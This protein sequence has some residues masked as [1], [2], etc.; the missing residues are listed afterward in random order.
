MPLGV[1]ASYIYNGQHYTQLMPFQGQYYVR[2]TAASVSCDPA[3]VVAGSA[4]TCTAT[5]L[6]TDGVPKTAQPGGVVTFSAQPGGKGTFSSTTCTLF[7]GSCSVTYTPSLTT[8]GSVTITAS[9]QGDPAHA[10]S[11]DSASLV[12]LDP[13]QTTVTG[14]CKGANVPVTTLTTC[15][16]TVVD[17]TGG[18]PTT[19]TGTVTMTDSPSGSGSFGTCTLS[20]VSVGTASCTVSYAPSAGEEGPITITATYNGDSTHSGSSGSTGLT[21]TQIATTTIV[22]CS[23]NPTS[24]NVASTCTATVSDNGGATLR[25]TGT[26]RFSASPSGDGS[27]SSTTCTLSSGSCSV[28]FTPS[29]SGV[30]VTITASYQ[31]DTD[32][33]VSSGSTVLTVSSGGGRS[34]STSISCS[35]PVAVNSPTTCTATV[36]DTS[37]GT[38]VTPT[39]TFTFSAP[40]GSGSFSPSNGQCTLSG[41]GGTATCTVS[42]TFTPGL[43]QEGSITLTG[44]YPGDGQHSGSSN[45]Q[46]ITA[47]QRGTSTSVTC[48]PT[49]G[50]VGTARTCTATVTDISPGTTVTPTGTVS[51]SVSPTGRGNFGSTTCN[52]S[53]G[54]C[55]VTYTPTA[56]GSVTI[57][58][59]YNGD[60]DHST[61]TG[62][63]TVTPGSG[64]GKDPTTTSVSCQDL[65]SFFGNEWFDCTATVT[66]TGS[67]PTTPTGTV[68][69]STSDS[70]GRFPFGGSTC[71][72]SRINGSSASCDVYYTF[73]TNQTDTITATYN[74]DSTHNGSSGFQNISLN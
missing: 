42:V 40:S 8:Q 38:K 51:F 72:L 59:S 25:P 34:T 49:S 16:V 30:S 14:P 50:G 19:P 26:V 68:S 64:G 57:T 61:S 12:V 66:D 65:G 6:D 32:H 62:T 7:F 69:W 55:S 2:S 74:S 18:T 47:T 73:G 28:S 29:V 15:T 37:G 10:G 21:A 39:G 36:S 3:P 5:V 20:Q 52:L 70:G 60:T 13:T 53:G 24:R 56:S 63:I 46:S 45:S 22:S 35:S 31:G 4:T 11:S 33:T 23:P 17:M 44:S 27:F 58:A 41:S 1:V 48:L 71:N 43:G 54:S 9:Y 67:S